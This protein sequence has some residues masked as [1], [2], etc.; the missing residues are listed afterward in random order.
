MIDVPLEIIRS[1]ILV[2]LIRTERTYVSG[3]IV[4]KTVTDHLVF[5]LEALSAL[6][7]RTALYG[8]I[9]WPELRVDICVGAGGS[10]VSMGSR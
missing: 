1:R 6:R 7:A 8:T 10:I 9:V 4:H 2:S 5:S 3:R